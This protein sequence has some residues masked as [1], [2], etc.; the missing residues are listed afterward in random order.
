MVVNQTIMVGTMIDPLHSNGLPG[1]YVWKGVFYS[2]RQGRM[3]VVNYGMFF[4]QD[5]ES[6]YE[7]QLDANYTGA[8][9]QLLTR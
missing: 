5:G 2:Q 9:T 8:A 3:R 4:I 7:W 6:D 1:V